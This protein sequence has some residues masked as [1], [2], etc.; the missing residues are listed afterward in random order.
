MCASAPPAEGFTPP[1]CLARVC[2]AGDAFYSAERRLAAGSG[3]GRDGGSGGRRGTMRGRE[4]AAAPVAR[5]ALPA[6]PTRRRST[7]AR[8]MIQHPAPSRSAATRMMS[9]AVAAEPV[10]EL[11]TLRP[12]PPQLPGMPFD[13]RDDSEFYLEMERKKEAGPTYTRDS[14]M[15]GLGKVSTKKSAKRDGGGGGGGGGGDALAFYLRTVAKVDLL[16]PHEEIVLGRQI[17][18]GVSYENTRDHLQLMRGYEPTEEEW[19]VALGMDREELVKELSRASKAKMAML[20][21][22]LRLVVSVAKR[23]RFQKLSFQ[24]LI[25]EGTFGLVKAAE[26]FDPERGFKF[27]TYATWWIKQSIM[28]GIADQSRIIRLPVHVHD[29]LNR[30]RKATLEMTDKNGKLP[31]D[32]ELAEHLEV[33]AVRIQYYRD[34]AQATLSM[35]APRTIASKTSTSPGKKVEMGQGVSGPEKTPDKQ[36]QSDVMKQKVTELLMTLSIRE[37]EVVK[38]R[39]GLGGALPRT[40]EEVG[41]D[42]RLTRERVRQI[43]ARALHKLRQPYRNY[44]VRDFKLD[45]MLVQAGVL[46]PPKGAIKAARQAVAEAEAAA[47]RNEVAL[48]HQRMGTAP[49]GGKPAGDVGITSELQS[50]VGSKGKELGEKEGGWGELSSSSRQEP[51]LD[52][53]LSVGAGGASVGRRPRGRP[54]NEMLLRKRLRQEVAEEEEEEEEEEDDA[55]LFEDE[56]ANELDKHL[57][58]D[59]EDDFEDDLAAAVFGSDGKSG[60]RGGKVSMDAVRTLNK[61]WTNTANSSPREAADQLSMMGVAPR[62]ADEE[63]QQLLSTLDSLNLLDDDDDVGGRA[64]AGVSESKEAMDR[65]QNE[66]KVNPMGLGDRAAAAAAAATA[67]S[68]SLQ[69]A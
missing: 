65:L 15:V 18:K 58:D 6:P 56:F 36:A 49:G 60:S 31:T 33:S 20:A 40:L 2:G 19:A 24:D 48:V 37:Q 50:I 29:F 61:A 51:L 66:M 57:D 13:M 28:R 5:G 25:Q 9:A 47:K 1:V 16:K 42:F 7:A 64:G 54:A 3:A 52:V 46:G 55:F 59:F 23:Y 34:A 12:P 21:A 44:R 10:E 63:E 27:S 41:R 68:R 35:E 11:D 53:G 67:S 4:A 32:E 69:A 30:V 38:A 26:K 17:Q 43:E 62:S 14:D 45:Q 8:W 22:N 39:F